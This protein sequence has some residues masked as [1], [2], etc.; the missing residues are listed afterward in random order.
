MTHDGCQFISRIQGSPGHTSGWAEK[1]KK[2][3][4]KENAKSGISI[5]L[6]F[7]ILGVLLPETPD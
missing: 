5:Q 2:Y 4:R 6:L 1:E 3:S 7:S